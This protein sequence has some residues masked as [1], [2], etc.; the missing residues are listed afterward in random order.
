[1][2]P[3]RRN[4]I[5]GRIYDYIREYGPCTSRQIAEGINSET[6][7][8]ILTRTVASVLVRMVGRG[9]IEKVGTE[10]HVGYI[11]AIAEGQA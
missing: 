7:G 10:I 2:T 1:M 3:I 11:Y 5:E 9:D 8:G 6:N 4:S